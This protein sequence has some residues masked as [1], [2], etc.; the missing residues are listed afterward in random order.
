MLTWEQ[1]KDAMTDG[2]IVATARILD[3]DDTPEFRINKHP[4][5]PDWNV[6]DS[7]RGSLGIVRFG[8]EDGG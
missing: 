3:P 1:L 6:P 7:L 2:E 5:D 8:A 4:A